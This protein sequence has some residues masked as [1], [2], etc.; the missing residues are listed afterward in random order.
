[1]AQSRLLS[2][3]PQ[4]HLQVLLDL[5][6]R[7]LIL[8]GYRYNTKCNIIY[9]DPKAQG[10]L[11]TNANLFPKALDNKQ[12][13]P[14][15][16][17]EHFDLNVYQVYK[18]ML[19]DDFSSL[20]PKQSKDIYDFACKVINFRDLLL[21]I[22]HSV[23]S[24][25]ELIADGDEGRADSQ[26]SSNSFD[27]EAELG[28]GRK[29]SNLESMRSEKGATKTK[30]TSSFHSTTGKIFNFELEDTF[31][32]ANP[33]KREKKFSEE[34]LDD[35]DALQTPNIY[36]ISSNQNTTQKE[37][38]KKA[39]GFI[40]VRSLEK[41]EALDPIKH[42]MLNNLSEIKVL[43]VFL[44]SIAQILNIIYLLIYRL[45][46]FI[47]YS[48]RI[49]N[50]TFSHAVFRIKVSSKLNAKLKS[51]ATRQPSK[52]STLLQEVSYVL[53]ALCFGFFDLLFGWICFLV[54]YLYCQEITDLL[55]ELQ[56][57]I[58]PSVFKRQLSLILENPAGIK[59]NPTY[60]GIIS[61][62]TQT[63]FLFQYGQLTPGTC[64]FIT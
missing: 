43:F 20:P 19:E 58:D 1:M 57:Y 26:R 60:C 14:S 37:K 47:F 64:A 18:D 50:S 9:Y 22:W 46:G 39:G 38:V 36:H 52:Y 10:I 29:D 40:D 61:K 41:Y 55:R 21:L 4:A 54:V 32:D 7:D 2:F 59:L 27:V 15:L 24:N 6:L 3:G 45:M 12:P 34:I 42:R 48:E 33:V 51:L 49:M 62:L 16:E 17:T 23:Y 11:G 56:K 35:L 63:I 8:C 28:F 44:A 25:K 53:N 13:A 30:H 31:L 5:N